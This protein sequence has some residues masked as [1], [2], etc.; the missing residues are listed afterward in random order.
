MSVDPRLRHDIAWAEAPGGVPVLVG[1][2]DG[3]GVPTAGYGH[4]GPDVVIGQTYTAQQCE[5]W[6]DADIASHARQAQQ[7]PEWQFLDT[8]CRC[9]AIVECVFN[10]GVKNWTDE[11][12]GTRRSIR[13]QDWQGA[14]DNLLKSPL[15]IKQVHLPRVQ[16]LANYLLWGAY[17]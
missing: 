7:T 14:H 6:L 16:R 9:N 8:P 12:P 5:D 4:T 1:Y 17:P 2:P 3:G 10:L 13:A 11:F 15:W